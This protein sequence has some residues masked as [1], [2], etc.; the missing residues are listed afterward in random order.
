MDKDEVL[1]RLEENEGYQQIIECMSEGSE[2]EVEKNVQ[3]YLAKIQ[4]SWMNKEQ[5]EYPE[6]GVRR[7]VE[8]KR[9]GR[10]EGQE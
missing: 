3:R 10:C 8:G 2:G 6:G 5:L 4:L 9:N 1:W 7:A